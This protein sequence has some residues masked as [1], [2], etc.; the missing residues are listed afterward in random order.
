MYFSIS[1]LLLKYLMSL[2]S[3]LIITD[4]ACCAR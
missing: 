2:Q 4:E 1:C 3:F